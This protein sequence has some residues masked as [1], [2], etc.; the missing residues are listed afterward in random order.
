MSFD[1]DTGSEGSSGPFINWHANGRQDG[2]ADSK[3]FSLKEGDNRSDI[4]AKFQKGVILDID[5]MKTGWNSFALSRWEWNDNVS[6]W[7]SKP[8]DG[9]DWKKGVSIQ[10]ALGGGDVGTWIQSGSGTWEA[11]KR[12]AP[13]LKDGQRGQLPM[14]KMTGVGNL[15]FTVGGT[16]YAE[17]E[18]I[19]WVD[20]PDS[21]DEVEPKFHAATQRGD[22]ALKA[23]VTP[24]PAAQPNEEF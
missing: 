13:Q 16:K 8:T 24:A 18:V 1:L 3:T 22:D 2:T 9:D 17:L 5:N 23:A 12:L 7:A 14:V 10:I 19:K 21:F 20:R 11:M 15:V 6:R 4:T